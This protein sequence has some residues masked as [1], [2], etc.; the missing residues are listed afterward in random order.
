MASSSRAGK[1]LKETHR[2]QAEIL[3]KGK[4][5]KSFESFWGRPSPQVNLSLFS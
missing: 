2:C 1:E 5:S 3:P 4:V